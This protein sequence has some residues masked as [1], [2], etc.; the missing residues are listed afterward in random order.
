MDS[1]TKLDLIYDMVSDMHATLYGNGNPQGSLLW[2][3]AQN[4]AAVDRNIT[5]DK[6]RAGAA[7]AAFTLIAWLM[8]HL[9][10]L[11]IM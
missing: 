7:A 1:T 9:P 8:S 10:T 5:I 3:V 6:K 4:K 2:T 11:P